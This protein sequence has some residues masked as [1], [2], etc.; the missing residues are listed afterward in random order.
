MI[1]QE[2]RPTR[3]RPSAFYRGI[4]FTGSGTAVNLVLLLLE[5][6]VVVRLLA[7]TSYGT[8]VLLIVIANFG[9]V[10]IDFG[11]KTSVTQMIAG[12]TRDRQI[13][14][15]NSALAFRLGLSIILTAI[16][17]LGHDLVFLL[18]PSREL[19]QLVYFVPFLM[20]W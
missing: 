20:I 12:A 7:P 4:F 5:T 2:Q 11:C 19:G 18:T 9:V 13:A 3:D 8:Y 14:V 10:A 16:V 1:A 6:L 15:A 17:W